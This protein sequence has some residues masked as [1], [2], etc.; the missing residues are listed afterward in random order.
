MDSI[1]SLT[2]D[3]IPFLEWNIE[4]DPLAEDMVSCFPPEIPTLHVTDPGIDLT[5]LSSDAEVQ[6]CIGASLSQFMMSKGIAPVMLTEAASDE[7][8]SEEV[9]SPL[10]Y[11]RMPPVS[12]GFYA[13]DWSGY[14]A[15]NDEFLTQV[16]R[17]YQPGDWILVLDY[18]LLLLP[19]LLRENMLTR[20]AFIACYLS[21]VFPSSEVIRILPE[22]EELLKGMLA[23]SFL[24]FHGF[25]YK[26]HFLTACTRVVGIESSGDRIEPDV[27]V[28][29]GLG[30]RVVTLPR[31]INTKP[32]TMALQDA[33]V[34]SQL[35]NLVEQ[36]HGRK[37]ILGVDS[38]NYTR[39][40]PNKLLAFSRFLA[41]NPEAAGTV[42]L[43]QVCIPRDSRWESDKR[44]EILNNAFQLAGLINATHGT[45]HHVPVHLLVSPLTMDEL[46]QLYCLADV[47]LLAP[48]RESL[49]RAAYEFV[50]CQS[51]SPRKGVL[52]L[53]EFSSSAACLGAA[54]L[55]VNP[56]DCQRLSE[57]IALALNMGEEERGLRLAFARDH[58]LRYDNNW[59]AVN[60]LIECRQ[61]VVELEAERRRIPRKLDAREAADMVLKCKRRVLILGVRG[62]LLY[63]TFRGVDVELMTPKL[64]L[65][66]VLDAALRLLSSDPSFDILAVSSATVNTMQLCLGHFAGITLL[67]ENGHFIRLAGSKTWENAI[68]EVDLSWMEPLADSCRYFEERTPGSVV[69]RTATSISF[70]YANAQREHGTSQARDLLMHLWSGAQTLMTRADIVVGHRCVEVRSS[71]TSK[72]QGVENWL[73]NLKLVDQD[74]PPS[75]LVMGNFMPRDEELLGVV[76]RQAKE[77]NAPITTFTVGLKPSRAKY[78]LPS[79]KDSEALLVALAAETVLSDEVAMGRV[80]QLCTLLQRP[81]RSPKEQIAFS[82]PDVV[83]RAPELQ[84]ALVYLAGSN[85]TE[86]RLKKVPATS[87]A[88][89]APQSTSTDHSSAESSLESSEETESED[90][91]STG[92]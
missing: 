17:Q 58:V 39:G 84:C 27:Y 22:R 71:A 57:A 19:R 29:G 76:E 70:N 15:L 87:S 59:W 80:T 69:V 61:A 85:A 7:R 73:R 46:V 55:R 26:R 41:E 1:S 9:L 31:G 12:T 35:T 62:T 72:G 74:P 49:S 3:Q 33:N 11:H 20:D 4:E 82:D 36:L 6:Q 81:K 10:F 37:V 56:W 66:R 51:L 38:L 5:R 64:R 42:T 77:W 83:R 28:G 24:G 2:M 13:E 86:A 40:I 78:Y 18:H 47:L 32:W 44:R 54:A 90:E 50:L 43:V 52:V 45:I 63:P 30:C 92:A 8:F 88:A 34:K 23:S 21:S 53:S 68:P 75:I 60:L 91:Y 16:V 89:A 65:P 25:Q 48:L 14:C 79:E 67:A